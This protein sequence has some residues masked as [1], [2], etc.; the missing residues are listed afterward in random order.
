MVSRAHARRLVLMALLLASTA[1]ATAQTIT[2][3]VSGHVADAQG[4]PLARVEVVARSTALQ[5]ERLGTT[6]E[7]GDFRLPGLPPGAY[8]LRFS[9][10]GFETTTRRVTVGPGQPVA[11]DVALGVAGIAVAVDV[12]APAV[13][14]F[15]RTALMATTFSQ[16]LASTLP[17]ARDLSATLLLAPAVHATGPGGAFSIAGA[18]SFESL[19]LINGVTVNENIRGQAQNL[20]IEDAIEQTTVAAGGVSAE[21]GRFS[22]GVVNMVTRSG[23]ATG[24]AAR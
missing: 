22:G 18:P 14:V 5:G 1:G 8:E 19:F 23:G 13:D 17:T 4:L 9:R 10:T 24:S 3:T 16:D 15:A 2:G 20:F 7:H 11:V 6:S 12:T 21:F